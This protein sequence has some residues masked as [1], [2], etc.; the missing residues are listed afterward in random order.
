MSEYLS[1][2]GIISTQH[3]S[4]DNIILPVNTTD[5]S[6]QQANVVGQQTDVSI[7]PAVPVASSATTTPGT[8]TNNQNSVSI[9]ALS[10]DIAHSSI[11]QSKPSFTSAS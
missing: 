6:H 10:L 8:S 2:L 9:L 11:P 4:A 1:N 3:V 5:V 7:S